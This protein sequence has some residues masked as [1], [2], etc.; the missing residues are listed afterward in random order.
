M[1]AVAAVT[2]S[3]SLT[4][5]SPQIQQAITLRIEEYPGRVRREQHVGHAFVPVGVAALLREYPTLVAPAVTAFCAR[6]GL[7]NKALRVM[8][9]FPP[10]QRVM[11]AVKFSKA[12]YAKLQ[13]SPY[14]P[15]VRTGWDLPLPSQP[16]YAAHLLG[17]KLACGFELL[18]C[19]AGG[20]TPGSSP[21]EPDDA[22]AGNVTANPRWGRYKKT[23]TDRGYFRGELEGS[24]LHKELEGNA[25][26]YFS[27]H[28]LKGEPDSDQSMDTLS[29]GA[30]VIKLLPTVNT[31]LDFFKERQNRL[32]PADDDSWLTIS[33]EILDEMLESRYGASNSSAASEQQLQ[34]GLQTFLSNT[35]DLEGVE[36]STGLED[37]LRKLSTMSLPRRK[38]S[39]AGPRKA[40]HG[41]KPSS[42]ATAQDRKI[43]SQS[44]ASNASDMSSF[45]SKMEFSADAFT[46]ALKN[47]LELGLPEDDYWQGS[48]DESSGLSSYGDDDSSEGCGRK[49]SSGSQDST[50]SGKCSRSEA[51]SDLRSAMRAM[52]DE[53]RC[54]TVAENM[55]PA[56]AA[57]LDSDDDAGE[58]DDVESFNPVKVDAKTVQQLV[59]AYRSERSGDPGPV[60]TLLSTIGMKPK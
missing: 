28:M 45:S 11:T 8:R 51:N 41:R 58:F 29:A 46:D 31:D 60:T 44:V 32:V 43:S 26:R 4:M 14:S 7:D 19:N 57:A 3:P 56:A 59:Q 52:E 55:R 34:S 18:V 38:Q 36:L 37:K 42:S 21:Q 24:K 16:D 5:A 25:L 39:A 49:I 50:S 12:L 35:S 48:D 27:Q 1:D 33:P 54:T 10:E 53:L 23:L 6:D 13:A 2:A 15:D 47:M 9:H 20:I 22:P 30:M 17:V 40:S